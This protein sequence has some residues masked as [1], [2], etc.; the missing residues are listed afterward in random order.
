M[1]R[2]SSLDGRKGTHL[3]EEYWAAHDL[4]FTVHDIMTQLLVSGQRARAFF[5]SFDLPDETAKKE[6]ESASDI[7][8][9]LEK[10]RT[11]EERA[12]V[13]VT[14][15]FP[16]VLSDMLHCFYEALETSRKAKLGISFM[17]LRKP[18]QES[19][20]V[21]EAVIADRA[22][23]AQKLTEDP[24]K[25]WSQGIGGR[26][27]HARNI[28]KVLDAVGENDRFDAAY[29]AQLRYDKSAADG[30]DGICNMA[31]HLFTE[32][33][34]IKTERLN[35][36]FIFS[37]WDSKLTQWSYIY[38]RLPYLLVYMHSIVEHVC[39]GIAPTSPAYLDDMKRRISAQALLWWETVEDPYIEPH[40]E[41]F[42]E[43]TRDWLYRH[44][45]AAGFSQPTTE[46]DLVRMGADGAFPGETRASVAKRL[47]Q[48]MRDASASGSHVP[49]LRARLRWWFK[50]KLGR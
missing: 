20:Y 5:V 26:E 45:D 18:L 25:L 29:L 49:T 41:T 10:H 14:T 44:C 23:F 36:N 33:K 9:W 21:L 15:M 31:M 7:F 17:L 3:P 24:I 39:Q 27:A 28:Q 32:H 30:F 8:E 37:K 50:E 12:A 4:C 43:R 19:L 38:S 2:F 46:A 42:A 22:G 35:I 34:S 11:P 48:F 40:L 1:S 16:A 47:D 13:L 6:F